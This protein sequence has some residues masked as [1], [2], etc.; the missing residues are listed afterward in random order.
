M[1][2]FP[3]TQA[4]FS[5]RPPHPPYPRRT[6]GTEQLML[7][8]TTAW[9]SLLLPALPSVP[10]PHLLSRPP[11]SLG[12]STQKLGLSS[13]L[14]RKNPNSERSRPDLL[15]GSGP[16]LHVASGAQCIRGAPQPWSFYR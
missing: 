14:R 4:A 16:F 9:A 5:P 8:W 1:T 7:Y 2:S 13:L 12:L 15:E 11:G 6:E 3:K 10:T